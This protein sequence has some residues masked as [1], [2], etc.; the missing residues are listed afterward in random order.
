MNKKGFP[1]R[2]RQGMRRLVREAEPYNVG[3]GGFLASPPGKLAPVR[4][5]VTDEA[6]TRVTA[7][8]RFLP[9]PSRLRR[10]TFPDGEV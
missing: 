4:T 10:A 7:D 6:K 1:L 5:L 3:R 8:F 2:G 9:H